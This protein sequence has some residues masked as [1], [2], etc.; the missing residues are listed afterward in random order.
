[1]RAAQRAMAGFLPLIDWPRFLRRPLDVA[2]DAPDVACFACGDDSQAVI[3]LLRTA[4]LVDG[5]VDP[6]TRSGVRLTSM[7][8][9][10]AARFYNP[11]TGARMGNGQSGTV[12][13]TPPFGACLAIAIG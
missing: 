8:P 1:M 2:C 9:P 5:L 10:G 12:L 3:F 4:P 13:A 6:A 11:V 7:L